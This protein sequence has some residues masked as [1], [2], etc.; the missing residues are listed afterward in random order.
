M[1]IRLP[2]IEQV[3]FI[4]AAPFPS[5]H[6]TYLKKQRVPDFSGTLCFALVEN[7]IHVYVIQDAFLY[8]SVID[9]FRRIEPVG[10]LSIRLIR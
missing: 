6:E 8:E 9:D 2:R 10:N 5:I 4:E 7:A 3:A 1:N